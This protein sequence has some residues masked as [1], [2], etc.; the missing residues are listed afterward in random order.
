MIKIRH[1]RQK[2]GLSQTQLAEKL[3]VQQSTIA[4]WESGKNTPRTD[5]LIEI[6]DVL[7][8]EISD[9]LGVSKA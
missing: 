3:R 4:M 6:A 8:C 5:K 7:D 1:Y 2:K 9:L